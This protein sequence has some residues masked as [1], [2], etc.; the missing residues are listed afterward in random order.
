VSTS[1]PS[2]GIDNGSVTRDVRAKNHYKETTST[3]K[4]RCHSHCKLFALIDSRSFR[5]D[6]HPSQTL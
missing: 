2:R 1:L 4:Q 6:Q 5:L 3:Q